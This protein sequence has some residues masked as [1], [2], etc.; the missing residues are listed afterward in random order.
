MLLAAVVGGVPVCRA[1][2][3]VGTAIPDVVVLKI[4]QRVYEHRGGTGRTLQMVGSGDL[5]YNMSQKQDGT[6]QYFKIG[7]WGRGGGAGCPG[8]SLGSTDLGGKL[9]SLPHNANFCP[10]RPPRTMSGHISRRQSPAPLC[11]GNGLGTARD[12]HEVPSSDRVQNRPNSILARVHGS[13]SPLGIIAKLSGT[14]IQL[15]I[16]SMTMAT[17]SSSRRL[18]PLGQ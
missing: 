2:A 8:P 1:S 11:A 7:N 6:G 9:A 3:F 4:R 13:S 5:F 17:A 10:R 16:R 15:R 14:S 12:R 18:A